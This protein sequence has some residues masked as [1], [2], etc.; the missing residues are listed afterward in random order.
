MHHHLS[1]FT[2]NEFC[3]VIYN[4][5]FTRFHT[6]TEKYECPILNVLYCLKSSSQFLV[7]VKVFPY[8]KFSLPERTGFGQFKIVEPS[9]AWSTK[10]FVHFALKHDVQNYISAF[11]QCFY[12]TVGNPY[13]ALSWLNYYLLVLVI[14]NQDNFMITSNKI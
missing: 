4:P 2:T 8:S 7:V 5:R 6:K 12:Y 3:G 14:I 10:A 13:M 9:F 1:L 11:V